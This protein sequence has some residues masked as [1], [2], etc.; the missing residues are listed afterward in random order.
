MENT[1]FPN[2]V[3]EIILIITLENNILVI[4]LLLAEI[5]FLDIRLNTIYYWNQ[6]HLFK[7]FKMGLHHYP[8][9]TGKDKSKHA[10]YQ[11]LATIENHWSSHTVPWECNTGHPFGETIWQFLMKLNITLALWSTNPTPKYYLREI[12][13]YVHSKMCMRMSVATSFIITPTGNDPIF[14][15]QIKE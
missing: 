10:T 5:K 6:F 9:G 12:K 4:A 11:A 7:L 3:W 2:L 14:H 1:R 8:Y 15:Q 13:T